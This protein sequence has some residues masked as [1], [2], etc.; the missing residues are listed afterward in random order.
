MDFR[1]PL[2]PDDTLVPRPRGPVPVWMLVASTPG[3]WLGVGGCGTSIR[4]PRITLPR[5]SSSNSAWSRPF[6]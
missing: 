3:V 2:S 5:A 4:V 1:L 6:R